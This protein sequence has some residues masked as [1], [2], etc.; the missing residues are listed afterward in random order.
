MRWAG[1]FFATTCARDEADPGVLLQHYKSFPRWILRS[2]TL[3]GALAANCRRLKESATLTPQTAPVASQRAHGNQRP[4]AIP[5]GR[6]RG[7]RRARGRGCRA[8]RP[9]AG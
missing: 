4:R 3:A 7:P 5:T 9:P 2:T 8:A 6:E 1:P